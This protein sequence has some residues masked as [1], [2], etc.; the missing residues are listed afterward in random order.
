MSRFKSFA[1][2]SAAALA[3]TG[4][5]STD[6]QEA[7]GMQVFQ[8]VVGFASMAV[9]LAAGDQNLAT[10]GA[11]LVDQSRAPT[12]T[13]PAYTPTQTAPAYQSGGSGGQVAAASPTQITFNMKSNHP[14]KVQVAFYSQTRRG[15]AWPGG[16]QAYGLND[17]SVHTHTLNCT[18]GEKICYGAWV[19]G[20]GNKYWGVGPNGKHGCTGCCTTC[21]SGTVSY[22]LNP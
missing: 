15:Y 14:N 18:P 20:T 2:A 6:G 8:Q 21:G 10:Q 22:T 12:T 7:G 5:A 13:T 17:Y 19:T 11:G 1:A 3:L 9:G 4:C 16:N